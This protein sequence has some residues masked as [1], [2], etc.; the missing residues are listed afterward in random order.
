MGNCLDKKAQERNAEE[1]PPVPSTQEKI[2]PKPLNPN[3]SKVISEM[4]DFHSS[5]NDFVGHRVGSIEDEYNI[6]GSSLGSGSFGEVRK[7]VHMPTNIVRAVKLINK[8]T[9]S[10]EE[11]LRLLNEVQILKKL[12]SLSR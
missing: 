2:L 11:R 4:K 7:A 9:T 8:D 10:K 1:K 5:S 3:N 6:L 12:V